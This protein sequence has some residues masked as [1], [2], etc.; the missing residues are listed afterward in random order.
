MR[1][2]KFISELKIGNLLLKR[3]KFAV[4]SNRQRSRTL[5]GALERLRGLKKTLS[6][7]WSA[8][9]RAL[10]RAK[11]QFFGISKIFIC[12]FGCA[13][14]SASH[15]R[16]RFFERTRLFESALNRSRAPSSLRE[17]P[18]VFETALDR[19]RAHKNALSALERSRAF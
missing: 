7:V 8:R 16:E 13:L 5:E 14:S 10:K 1:R 9:E 3:F 2:R 15:A 18:R 12:R 19:S 4:S 17:H 6:N 11:R